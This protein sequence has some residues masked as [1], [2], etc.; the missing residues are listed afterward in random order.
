MLCIP[1]LLIIEIAE[2]PA[3]VD[4]V[5][6]FPG[7]QNISGGIGGIGQLDGQDIAGIVCTKRILRVG[8]DRIRFADK[9]AVNVQRY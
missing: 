2:R 7:I 8:P 4:F 3:D 5:S 9:S 1:E 6:L